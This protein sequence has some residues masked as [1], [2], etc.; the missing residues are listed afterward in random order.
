MPAGFPGRAA[1]NASG[2]GG[3]RMRRYGNDAMIMKTAAENA[4]CGYGNKVARRRGG[5]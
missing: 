5:G 3:R 1:P 4:E 2:S